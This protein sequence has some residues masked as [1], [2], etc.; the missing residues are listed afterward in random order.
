MKQLQNGHSYHANSPGHGPAYRI[1]FAAFVNTT[2]VFTRMVTNPTPI[3]L[4]HPT[5][6][7]YVVTVDYSFRSGVQDR[8]CQG[9]YAA[10]FVSI[11][12]PSM[13]EV[14]FQ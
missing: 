6:K 7:G 3:T 10:P 11:W 8:R 2:T 4:H 5:I 13:D 12:D 14:R 1:V 9:T